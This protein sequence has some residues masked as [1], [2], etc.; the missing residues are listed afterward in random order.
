MFY[1]LSY[2]HLLQPYFRKIITSELD[3]KKMLKTKT[4][5]GVKTQE[6]LGWS[7][8]ALN[9]PRVGRNVENFKQN[10]MIFLFVCWSWKSEMSEGFY[11]AAK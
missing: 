8:A 5:S 1:G 2:A 9:H 10:F 6:P 7:T 3:G 11:T 4:G